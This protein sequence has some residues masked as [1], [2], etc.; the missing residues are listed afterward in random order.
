MTWYPSA[1][2]RPISGT[3]TAGL[4]KDVCCFHTA[5]G[6]GL[7]T[8]SYFNQ[9]AVQVYSHGV[10][11]GIWGSDKGQNVDG[12]ALQMADTDFRAAANLD[13]N[14]HVIA[15]ET[16]DNGVRPI[17]PWTPKQQT[18]IVNIMVDA[19]RLDGIPMVLIP[20][21]RIGRRGFGYHR[22]GCDPY[23]V[24][25]GELWSA[26]FGKDCPTDPRIKQFPGLFAQARDIVAGKPS[27]GDALD[28]ATEA[29]VKLWVM[30]TLKTFTNMPHGLLVPPGKANNDDMYRTLLGLLQTGYNEQNMTQNAV[31]GLAA[32]I[33]GV[34]ADGDITGKNEAAMLA[35]LTDIQSRVAEL[36]P[37]V[38]SP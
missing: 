12:L 9:P 36:K 18:K 10:I 38:P 28:M 22:L 11:C 27:T 8:W 35:Q 5:V 19:H 16:G 14:W 23:R 13:G 31:A 20:D 3:S 37:V 26:A 17:Q 29:E 6:G 34:R 4:Q 32:A 1:T 25:G 7:S 21:T 15:W 24:S 2:R 33:A 30:E